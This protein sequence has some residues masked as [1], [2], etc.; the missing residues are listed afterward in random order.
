MNLNLTDL[1]E[2]NKIKADGGILKKMKKEITTE[3]GKKI[4]EI[5]SSKKSIDEKLEEIL[6]IDREPIKD[7]KPQQNYSLFVRSYKSNWE[8]LKRAKNRFLLLR[9]L[10]IESKKLNKKKWQILSQIK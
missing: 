9:E 6:D 7:L 5:I 8:S 3:K 4:A 1:V 2:K 10:E